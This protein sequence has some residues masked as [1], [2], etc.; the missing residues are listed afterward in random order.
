M[1]HVG[2]E[3]GLV[4]AGRLELAV[5][6]PY[7]RAHAVQVCDE[8]AQLIPVGNL[9]SFGKVARGDLSHARLHQLHR[10]HDGRRDRIAEQQRQD[11]APHRESYHRVLR[12]DVGTMARLDAGDHVGLGLVHQLVGEAL[13]PVGKRRGLGELQFLSFH[14]AAAANELDHLGDD[15]DE[16]LVVLAHAGEQLLLVLGYELQTV[17]VVAEL[18]EL[19]QG[20]L[21][22]AVVGFEQGR[23]DAIELADGVVVELPVGGDLALQLHHVLGALVHL[24]QRSQ[25]HNPGDQHQGH[26]RQERYEQLGEHGRARACDQIGQPFRQVFHLPGASSRSDLKSPRNSFGS[27][28]DPR[29]CTRSVPDR[30]TIEVRNV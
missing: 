28:R 21:Q 25:P 5:E 16:L 10:P 27:K 19:P 4:L 26:D 17:E 8:R 7:L 6:P 13:E 14:S 24:G 20:R 9:D 30:S 29:Y 12:T 15:L 23:G 3:L 22:P 18:I 2:Q 1:G 11:D